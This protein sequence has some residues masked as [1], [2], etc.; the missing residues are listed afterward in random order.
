MTAIGDFNGDGKAVVAL[1]FPGDTSIAIYYS[2]GDGTFYPGA[3]VDLGQYPGGI[4]AGDFDGDGRTDIAVALMLSQQA[5]LLF[6][7]GN[8]QFTR[9]FLPLARMRL[10]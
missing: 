5:C 2:N 4:V 6:N 3:I 7:Q 8:G 1:S 9:S 10:E